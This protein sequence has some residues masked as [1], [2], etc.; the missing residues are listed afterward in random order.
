MCVVSQCPLESKVTGAPALLSSHSNST[1]PP[2]PPFPMLSYEKHKYCLRCRRVNT[3]KLLRVWVQS[4]DADELIRLRIGRPRRVGGDPLCVLRARRWVLLGLLEDGVS[5]RRS[6]PPAG[7]SKTSRRHLTS[8]RQLHQQQPRSAARLLFLN[9]DMLYCASKSLCV[10]YFGIF[11]YYKS[12]ISNNSNTDS[13][14]QNNDTFKLCHM[15]P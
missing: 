9:V 4:E 7:G 10:S 15:C 12:L 14:H 5:V 13:K 8:L 1:G 11:F 6:I 3:P 2:P